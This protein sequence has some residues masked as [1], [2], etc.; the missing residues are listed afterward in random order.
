[1]DAKHDNVG[2]VGLVVDS[3]SYSVPLPAW[4]QGRGI[5]FMDNYVERA[6]GTLPLFPAPIVPYSLFPISTQLNSFFVMCGNT[7]VQVITT[8]GA[9]TDISSKVYS[10][11]L[12]TPWTGGLLGG[13]L[14]LNN[15]ADI[16]QYWSNYDTV[17]DLVDLPDWPSVLRA[18]VIRPIGAYIFMGDVVESATRFPEKLRWSAAAATGTLPPSYDV[19][20]PTN[21]SNE[22][23]CNDKY[24]SAIKDFQQLRS[25]V[26]AYKERAVF[27]LQYTG[28]RASVWAREQ[29]LTDIGVPGA[30]CVAVIDNGA[31]HV[32]TNGTD[33]FRWNGSSS[34]QSVLQGKLRKWV[35]QIANTSRLAHNFVVPLNYTS[36]VL[37]GIVTRN[38]TWA[39]VGILYNWRT[40]TLSTLDL[41]EWTAYTP[42][43]AATGNTKTWAQAT[44]EGTTWA[45]AV[46]TWNQSSHVSGALPVVAH[47]TA[48]TAGLR[49]FD[50]S[51]KN[52]GVPYNSY[53]ERT[54][55]DLAQL[56]QNK[57][58]AGYKL[59]VRNLWPEM[60]GGEVA[61]RV[62]FQDEPDGPVY[63]NP[64]QPFQP[65]VD[66]KV[67]VYAGGRYFCLRIEDRSGTHWRLSG[68]RLDVTTMGKYA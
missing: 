24:G 27:G 51:D 47:A 38:K 65:G 2:S 37:F 3:A 43:R 13:L 42:G 4:T 7:S 40:N 30:N 55:L 68:Y 46:G 19:T 39:D 26:F 31:E 59:F 14:V 36:E 50:T 8:L 41:E 25:F 22:V 53:V 64:P 48:G 45:Q 63:W 21:D 11:P 28:N 32:F 34:P 5:R 15:G 23:E 9:I 1:M 12:D 33:L 57:N 67:D 62:G 60:I 54:G 56:I 49:V 66:K 29:V 6:K 44:L 10:G 16:P 17:P 35:E 61:I 20:D 52:N 18:K 58:L